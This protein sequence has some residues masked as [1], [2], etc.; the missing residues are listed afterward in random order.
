MITAVHRQTGE[1]VLDGE[2]I[3]TIS[4]LQ[5]DRVVGY[6]RQPFPL[7]PEPGMT[8]VLTTRA[9]KRTR[10]LGTVGQIGAQ[11]EYI[12]NSLAVI[13]A[14]TVVD[15]GLPVVINLPP[16]AQLRPGEIVDVEIQNASR[17]AAGLGAAARPAESQQQPL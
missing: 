2:P 12:T 9:W 7:V 11:L 16:H 10:F 3:V 6:L 17:A 4:S 8:A 15:A 1:H 5:S 14:G 13:R